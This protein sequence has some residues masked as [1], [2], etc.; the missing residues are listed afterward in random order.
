MTGVFTSVLLLCVGCFQDVSVEVQQ[1][2]S[3]QS[4]KAV[5]R[6]I[7]AEKLTVQVGSQTKSFPIQTLKSLQFA[8]AAASEKSSGIVVALSDGSLINPS[9]VLAS[10]QAVQLSL[11]PSLQISVPA[12]NIASVRL[13]ELNEKQATQWRAIQESRIAGDTLVVIRSTE[14]VDKVEG[15]IVEINAERVLF[16]FNKQKIEA[17]R[18]KL[19]GLRFLTPSAKLQRINAVV[20]DV[21][22]N[23][24][25]VSK[26][27]SASA[28]SVELTLACG[29]TF[30]LPISQLKAIDFSVGSIKYVAELTPLAQ[31]QANSLALK[32][33]IAGVEQL[34]GP[35]PVTIPQSPGPSIKMLGSGSVTYRVPQEYVGLAGRVYLAPEGEQFT[36]CSVEIRQE[37][38]VVWKGRLTH[39]ND[40]LDVSAKIVPESRLQLIVAAD[41]SYPVGDAV[42]WQELRMMK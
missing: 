31:K 19:A 28:S 25:Q 32:T 20:T 11:S 6:G 10:S 5:W 41:S 39:P 17:P 12:A 42:I 38:E 34:F 37:N 15:S 9:Q 8:T 23:S 22:G 33:P 7:D 4:E 16:E 29:A 35:Q 18:A 1:L 36:A 13:Q 24:L 27:A 21:N 30:Q 14:S 40:R 3:T 26:V 2:T